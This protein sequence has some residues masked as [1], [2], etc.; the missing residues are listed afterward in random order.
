MSASFK[1][2]QVRYTVHLV[3]KVRAMFTNCPID[4]MSNHPFAPPPNGADFLAAESKPVR[5][6][7]EEAFVALELSNPDTI[8]EY[9]AFMSCSGEERLATYLQN[10]CD[11]TQLM[12]DCSAAVLGRPGNHVGIWLWYSTEWMAPKDL[13]QILAT[14]AISYYPYAWSKA[15]C[16]LHESREAAILSKTMKEYDLAA[17]QRRISA[18]M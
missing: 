16:L 2:H 8:D 7:I 11:N 15:Y 17:I 12:N 10:L 18:T 13:Y 4:L 3:L 9:R 1:Y 5:V 14:R 6:W